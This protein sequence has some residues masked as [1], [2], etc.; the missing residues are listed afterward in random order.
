MW[1]GSAAPCTCVYCTVLHCTVL[2]HCTV[3]PHLHGHGGQ[4]PGGEGR[5]HAVPSYQARQRQRDRSGKIIPSKTKNIYLIILESTSYRCSPS[6]WRGRKSAWWY[7][8]I[9]TVLEDTD[10]TVMMPPPASSSLFL[11]ASSRSP[12]SCL[13][14]ATPSPCPSPS[15]S[16]LRPRQLSVHAFH[17]TKLGF[18]SARAAAGGS[19]GQIVT[20]YILTVALSAMPYPGPGSPACQCPRRC[21]RPCWSR[22]WRPCRRAGPRGTQG[23]GAGV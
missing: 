15:S 6:S 1:R 4:D 8:N 13:I 3:L 14:L 22:T 21:W 11:S 5:P 23:P 16:S 20:L 19:S 12:A 9:T 10:C 7:D 17:S 18:F 2:Y